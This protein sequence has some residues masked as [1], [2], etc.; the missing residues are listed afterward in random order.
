MDA[1]SQY[2]LAYSLTTAAGV[3][4]VL[5]LALVAV[6]THLGLLHPP[7]SFSWLASPIAMWILIAVGMAELLGD[8]IPVL[9]HAM[10]VLQIAIKPAA[11]AIIVGGTVHVQSNEMLIFLMVVGALNA[12]GVHAGVM[13]VRGA[14]TVTTGG[15][16]NPAVSAA[17]DVGTV[18]TVI[19]AFVAP[20]VAAMLAI[21]VAAVLINSAVRGM[22]RVTRA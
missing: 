6:A 18:C 22:R 20:V 17:E 8:K 19:L 15:L 13:T 16:A 12:L 1:A 5:A 10:H 21:C 3:R 2:A 11:A 7:S 4:A 9:D 14:S